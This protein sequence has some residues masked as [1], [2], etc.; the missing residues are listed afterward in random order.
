MMKL[1]VIKGSIIESGKSG[2]KLMS[3]KFV[4]FYKQKNPDHE[5]IE[6]DLN[7]EKTASISLSEKNFATFW[8]DIESEKYINLLKSVDKV[9]FS[10][11]MIN[12]NY[13]A[14]V[15]NFIDAIS[16]ANVTFSYKYSKKGDA[17]GLL[18]HLKVQ[19][20]TSQGAPAD[21]YPF[22]L[23]T[24]NLEGYWKFLGAKVVPSIKLTGTKVAPFSELTVDEKVDS[25]IENIKKAASE[26]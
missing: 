7:Q 10:T 9:L 23:F 2:S 6:L 13:S 24:E 15:K 11:S 3:D 20:L 25:I 8:K 5:I 21:W 18:D 4:E 16:V 19:I 1:L 17:K 26:F 12:F 14:P 22:G